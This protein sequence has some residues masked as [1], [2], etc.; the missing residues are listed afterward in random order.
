[1]A[2]H[3]DG[4]VLLEERPAERDGV[5]VHP[6]VVGVHDAAGE[7]ERVV[8]GGVRLRRREIHRLPVSVLALDLAALRCH[9]HGGRAGR[10][11]GLPRGGELTVFV[12]VR[13][14]ERDLLSGE[15]SHGG[16][17]TC[18]ILPGGGA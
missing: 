8:L 11:D 13:R 4:L 2:D 18:G 10:G 6:Q 1:V 5:P 17:V 12:S 9:H 14:E 16:H 3:A 15:I 7:H